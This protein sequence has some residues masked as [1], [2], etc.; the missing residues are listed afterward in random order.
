MRPLRGLLVGDYKQVVQTALHDEGGHGQRLYFNDVD[1]PFP[2]SKTLEFVSLRLRQRYAV[3]NTLR[4]LQ[5]EGNI[6]SYKNMSDFFKIDVSRFGEH[7]TLVAWGQLGAKKFI[8]HWA[9]PL[10]VYVSALKK[11]AEEIPGAIRAHHRDIVNGGERF[12]EKVKGIENGT[13][14]LKGWLWE[15]NVKKH[16]K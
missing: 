10:Y 6:A 9:S 13:Y 2:E 4:W 5:M 16:V 1:K 7:E 15:T 12:L 11:Y 3:K 14:S 8:S